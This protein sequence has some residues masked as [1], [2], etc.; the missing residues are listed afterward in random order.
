MEKQSLA[1]VTETAMLQVLIQSS[2]GLETGGHVS[3]APSERYLPI[4]SF[5]I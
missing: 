2:S 3:R 1:L 4:N 5:H